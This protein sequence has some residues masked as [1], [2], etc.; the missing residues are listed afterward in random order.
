MEIK[1]SNI[2]A[3][4]LMIVLLVILWK[5][6]PEIRMFLGSMRDIGPGPPEDMAMGLVAFALIGILV[7]AIV[8]IL[9]SG[10]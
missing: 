6:A 4:A 10:R 7:V 9:V 5:A 2:V 1:W 8:R 3:L